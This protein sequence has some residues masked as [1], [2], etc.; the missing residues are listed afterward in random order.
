MDVIGIGKTGE[1]F[2]LISDTNCC[3]AVHWIIPKRPSISFA[4]RGRSLWGTKGIPYL[5]AHGAHTI[6]YPLIKVND[7]TQINLGAGKITDFSKFDPGN[8]CVVTRGANQGRTDLFTNRERHT[9][10]LVLLM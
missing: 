1:N 9:H 4:E 10:T 6:Y 5:V 8:L 2:C 3:F 7:T